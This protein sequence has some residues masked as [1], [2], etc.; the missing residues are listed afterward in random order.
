[1]DSRRRRWSRGSMPATYAQQLHGQELGVGAPRP[2]N[3][4][5]DASLLEVG[6]EAEQQ[7]VVHDR[8]P[9]MRALPPL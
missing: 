3:G 9:T 2:Q 4:G 6:E 7:V 5:G 1:M 8:M